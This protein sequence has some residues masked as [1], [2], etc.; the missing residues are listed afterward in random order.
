MGTATA[1]EI[2][3]GEKS[4]DTQGCTR[5]GGKMLM[6]DFLFVKWRNKTTQQV[7]EDR[8]ELKSRLP[9][10][11][12]MR[13]TD[14]Y[15]LID[16]DKLYVYLIPQQNADGTLNR[17]PPNQQPNGPEGYEYLDV[18]TLYPDNAQPKVRGAVK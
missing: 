9:S 13:G 1:Q 8:V 7:F 3:R 17:R 10:P 18:R 6:G 11:K 12:E 16:D 14:V 15:F 5:G 2:A 4:L